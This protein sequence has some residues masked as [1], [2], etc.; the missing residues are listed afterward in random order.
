MP[1]YSLNIDI[2]TTDLQTIYAANELVTIVKQSAAGPLVAW[3][4]FP[5][6]EAN[7]LTWTDSYALYAS[8]TSVQGGAVINQL[9]NILAGPGLKYPFLNGDFGTATPDGALPPNTYETVNQMSAFPML[10]F[11]L[12][13]DIQLNG[14][15]QPNRPINA[16]A[17]PLNQTAT[18]TPFDNIT[19][20]LQSQVQSSMMLTTVT[21]QSIPLQ[22]GGS[23]TSQ[24]ISYTAASGWTVVNPLAAEVSRLRPALHAAVDTFIDSA[25]GRR[26]RR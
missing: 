16:Q 21:S 11:G 24:T 15:A 17:V 26:A 6:F 9:S 13:Q 3:V 2:D 4:A 7:T 25:M 10:T 19:V 14:K 5:P 8:N 12:A 1:N 20:F 18:F 22:F 23:T